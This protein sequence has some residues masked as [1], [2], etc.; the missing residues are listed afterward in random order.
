MKKKIFLVGIISLFM[1]LGL[2]G[3]TQTER[4]SGGSTAA[5]FTAA[6]LVSEGSITGDTGVFSGGLTVDSFKAG[7]DDS[8]APM[9]IGAGDGCS[10]ILFAASSTITS[11]A[12]STSFCK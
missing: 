9:Y 10:Y 4:T 11:G 3:C 1:V 2:T 6:N 5:T 8:Y 12:T 7:D